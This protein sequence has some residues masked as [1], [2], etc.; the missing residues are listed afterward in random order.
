MICIISL[1]SSSIRFLIF[2][3]SAI[4]PNGGQNSILNWATF[5]ASERHHDSSL[6]FD[7]LEGRILLFC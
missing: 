5:S 4:M 2:P 1:L 6:D 7:A 3:M